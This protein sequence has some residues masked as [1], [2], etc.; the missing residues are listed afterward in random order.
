M[1][2]GHKFKIYTHIFALVRDTSRSTV[3]VAVVNF[4]DIV[5]NKHVKNVRNEL[6]S[7]NRRI[8]KKQCF[9]RFREALG[10]RKRKLKPSRLS[11]RYFYIVR[12]VGHKDPAPCSAKRRIFAEY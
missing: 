11:C 5:F 4:F 6:V 10:I 8:V 7:V 3:Y 9:L 12:L 1:V 2:G